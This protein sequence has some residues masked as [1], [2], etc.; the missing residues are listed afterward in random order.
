MS[1]PAEPKNT[2]AA[3]FS[4][5]RFYVEVGQTKVAVFTEIS[6][7]QIE[8]ETLEVLE[9]GRNEYAQKLPGRTKV[10]NVTLK[11]GVIS[12][13][14]DGDKGLVA[15]L[16]KTMQGKIERQQLSVI[17]YDL[18][19]KPV[20]RWDFTKAI[21]VKWTGPQFQATGNT[22]AIET[23]EFAHLGV[24]MPKKVN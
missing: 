8:I 1:N 11:R 19:G 18:V 6:G 23:F 24:S 4:N 20:R 2:N 7:L 5:N 13:Q 16:E 17:M 12:L 3:V 9:G 14:E 10:G 15:W 22:A 21:P